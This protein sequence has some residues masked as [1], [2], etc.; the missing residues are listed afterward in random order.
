MC[1]RTHPCAQVTVKMEP[2][3]EI[4]SSETEMEADKETFE[5]DASAVPKDRLVKK[6]NAKA[7]VWRCFGLETELDMVKDPDLPVYRVC[8][9]RVKTKHANTSNLYSHLKKQFPLLG[10]LAR[11]YLCICAT[12]VPSERV[13][14]ARGNIV[15]TSQSSLKPARVDQLVFLAINLKQFFLFLYVHVT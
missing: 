9:E 4:E 7:A 8:H 13:F 3:R 11:R 6:R 12:S 10:R 14:S 5:R 15:T 1:M 2:D